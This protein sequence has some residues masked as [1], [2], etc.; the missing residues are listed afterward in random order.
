VA[1][2]PAAR[3]HHRL[4]CNINGENFRILAV[5]R[6]A[7]WIDQPLSLSEGPIGVFTAPSPGFAMSVLREVEAERQRQDEKWGEQNCHDFEWVS[8]LTEEAGEAAA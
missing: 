4:H 1:W 8:I 6:F 2:T 5:E 7:R 3:R